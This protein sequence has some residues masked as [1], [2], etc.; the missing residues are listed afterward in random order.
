MAGKTFFISDAY[1]KANTPINL[2]VEPTLL[3]MAIQDAQLL[4]VQ[5]VLGTRL[6]KKLETLISTGAIAAAGNEAYKTLLDDYVMQAT[7]QWALAESIPYIRYKIMNKSVGGQS[8]DNSAPMELEELK[9]M[10]AQ[11]RNRAEYYTQRVADH[12]MA[13]MAALPEYGQSGN[14][15]EQPAEKNAYFGGMQLDSPDGCE[16]FMGYNKNTY[17]L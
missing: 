5:T 10:Q 6:Y 7:A 1:L 4:H 12:C 2:N 17:D 14:V 15:D 13:N 8:S 9:Y 3:S 11:L 16:R